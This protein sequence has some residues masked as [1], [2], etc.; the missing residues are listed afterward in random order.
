MSTYDHAS[1]NL[2]YSKLKVLHD[3]PRLFYDSFVAKTYTRPASKS[4]QLGTLMHAILLNPDELQNIA[5]MKPGMRRGTNAYTEWKA[6]QKPNAI[7]VSENEYNQAVDMCSAIQSHKVAGP[8][9]TGNRDYE[10][11]LYGRI[12]GLPFQA[13]PDIL[14]CGLRC[15]ADLKTIRDIDERTIRYAIKDY[16]Y[17]LQIAIY[18]ELANVPNW[19]WIFVVVGDRPQ[20]RVV[21]PSEETI[22]SGQAFLARLC[23]EYKARM[24]SG[25]WDSPW[26]REESEIEFVRSD[27]DESGVTVECDIDVQ[28]SESP[29]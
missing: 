27:E 15:V 26:D 3:D 16:C 8:Y 25:D 9:F 7:E 22:A 2:S 29:F 4:M 24:Q 12:H 17:D 21:R 18:C 28:L 6:K 13:K 14:H 10:Q 1:D 5:V 11:P 19:R 20:I 23:D